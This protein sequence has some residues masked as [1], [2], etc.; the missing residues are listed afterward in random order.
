MQEDITDTS[1][2][3]PIDLDTG[4]TY[5]WAIRAGNANGWGKPFPFRQ[6]TT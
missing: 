2:T 3:L 6:Y 1:L 4:V 5:Q